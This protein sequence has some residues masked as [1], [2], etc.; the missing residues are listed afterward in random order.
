MPA[1]I[2][3]ALS[4]NRIGFARRLVARFRQDKQPPFARYGIVLSVAEYGEQGAT[5][6]QIARSMGDPI[7][8]GSLDKIEDAGLI[9]RLPDTSPLRFVLTET[10][11]ALVR[12]LTA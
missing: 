1:N 10:G 7:I 2:A 6:R 3:P 12:D 11:T 8:G 5:A 9:R 4:N